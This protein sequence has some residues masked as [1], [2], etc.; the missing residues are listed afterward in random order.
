MKNAWTFTCASSLHFVC[1]NANMTICLNSIIIGLNKWEKKKEIFRNKFTCQLINH[2]QFHTRGLLSKLWLWELQSVSETEDLL[3]TKQCTTWLCWISKNGQE[4]F[5]TA[6]NRL[7]GL[8]L[9]E[10]IIRNK[11]YVPTAHRLPRHEQTKRICYGSK[12]KAWFL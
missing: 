2:K 9:D 12:V 10:L 3:Y 11:M 5:H 6:G 4:I 8:F 7:E 1:S